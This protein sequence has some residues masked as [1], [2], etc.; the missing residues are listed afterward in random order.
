MPV[1]AK[2]YMRSSIGGYVFDAVFHENYKHENA[3]TKN[4]VQSGAAVTDHVFRQPTEISF[5]V[6][7]SDCMN[8]VIPGQ[9]EK[10]PSRAATA[11]MIFFGLWQTAL[12][13]DIV[14]NIDG[15]S[16]KYSDMVIK[17]IT[18][19]NDRTTHAA[20]RMTINLQQVIRST[21]KTVGLSAVQSSGNANSAD[22]QTTN[23]TN[24]G[25]ASAD[26]S[27]QGDKQD[28][29]N[30]SVPESGGGSWGDSNTQSGGGS[31]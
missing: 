23:R 19:I 2:A 7:V 16:V 8:S 28:K 12:P 31:W 22:P 6:G 17:T 20:T 5:D 21:A 9:F 24:D 26:T 1:A 30:E 14:S 11:Y 15:V 27:N 25:K 10:L 13:L 3:I 18:R 4:P 29:W